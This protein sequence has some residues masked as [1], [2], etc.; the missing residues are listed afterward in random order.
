M[1]CGD[2]GRQMD[3]YFQFEFVLLFFMFVVLII[4]FN[5]LYYDLML[6]DSQRFLL[7][8]EGARNTAN[9]KN[10]KIQS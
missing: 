2:S 3:F 4:L 10:K 9:A 7:K 1:L 5:D 6:N 8:E